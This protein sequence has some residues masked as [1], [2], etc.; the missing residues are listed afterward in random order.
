MRTKSHHRKFDMIMEGL[1][2]LKTVEFKNFSG[3]Y[4]LWE[5]DNFNEK[6]FFNNME[7]RNPGCL[8]V[9]NIKVFAY[10]LEK[11]IYRTAKKQ[12]VTKQF[13]RFRLPKNF[14]FPDCLAWGH[15]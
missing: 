1:P 14:E 4:Q 11:I 10:N 3:N 12:F 15:V 7:I 13:E 8:L 2:A 6:E 9:W 5:A